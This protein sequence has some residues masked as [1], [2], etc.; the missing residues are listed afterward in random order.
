MNEVKNT[1]KKVLAG[2][3]MQL[4]I[5]LR[6]TIGKKQEWSVRSGVRRG[7]ANGGTGGGGHFELSWF[8]KHHVST[9]PPGNNLQVQALNQ[10]ERN[11]LCTPRGFLFVQHSSPRL[12]WIIDWT[13]H[14]YSS[15]YLSGQFINKLWIHFGSWPRLES[16]DSKREND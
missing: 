9:R 16:R 4:Q 5:A 1:N 10:T 15:R 14:P 7:K 12:L 6:C 2:T 13:A 8:G 3:K 11:S